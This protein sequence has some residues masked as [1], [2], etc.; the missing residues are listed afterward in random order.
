M[1]RALLATKLVEVG[2]GRRRRPALVGVTVLEHSDTT[3]KLVVDTSLTSIRAVLD[4]LL[5]SAAVST[6]PSSTRR[7][8]RSSPRSTGCHSDERALA[9][10]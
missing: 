9:H 10:A 4:A 3:M 8:S 6:S 2:L 5:D 1:R 7:S